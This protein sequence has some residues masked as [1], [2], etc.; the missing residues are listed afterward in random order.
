MNFFLI[1]VGVALL[2]F[3]QNRVSLYKINKVYKDSP[4]HPKSFLNRYFFLGHSNEIGVPITLDNYTSFA[5]IKVVEYKFCGIEYSIKYTKIKSELI[6]YEAYSPNLEENIISYAKIFCN[7]YTDHFQSYIDYKK[8]IE[9][10]EDE[11]LL[12]QIK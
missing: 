11:V 2:L 10:T 12:L 9:L 5:V 7:M 8:I 1:L 4:K 6:Y 3:L